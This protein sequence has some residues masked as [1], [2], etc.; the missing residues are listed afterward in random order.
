MNRLIF[1]VWNKEEKK[2]VDYPVYFNLIN[3]EVVTELWYGYQIQ[4][5]EA[6][7]DSKYIVQQSTGLKDKNGK[8]IF[9]GD[10]LKGPMDY[11]PAGYIEN[12]ASVS[13]HK[14]YGF[15]LNYFLLNH[16]EIIG[17]VFENKELLEDISYE[18]K[19]ID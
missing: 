11:G 9:E 1:R 4:I 14:H 15:Q 2:F 19:R 17:N 7:Q 6:I 5:E 3:S 8:L 18:N 10:I 12:I 13:Y 16:T